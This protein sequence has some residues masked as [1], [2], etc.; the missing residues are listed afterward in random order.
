MVLVVPNPQKFKMKGSA[1]ISKKDT[2]L[3]NEE[4]LREAARMNNL[5]K[6][7]ILLASGTNPNAEDE[8]S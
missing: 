7:R 5:R 1:R 4:K 6:F 3:V 2:Q 8:V